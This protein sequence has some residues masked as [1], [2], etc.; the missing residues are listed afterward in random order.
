[1]TSAELRREKTREWRKREL[2]EARERRGEQGAMEFWLR[3]VRTAIAKEAKAGRA[4]VWPAY[5]LISR[6]VLTAIQRRAAGDAR[7]WTDLLRYAEQV[8]DRHPPHH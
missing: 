4:D 8:V 1:M 7:I 3:L 6:L 2:Q 5:A